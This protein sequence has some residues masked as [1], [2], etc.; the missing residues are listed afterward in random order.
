MHLTDLQARS[1]T[2]EELAHYCADHGSTTERA[3]AAKVD[4]LTA[5]LAEWKRV[6][7]QDEPVDLEQE[8]DYLRGQQETVFEFISIAETNSGTCDVET[9][10]D[11]MHCMAR[12]ESSCLEHGVDLFAP[13]HELSRLAKLDSL[14]S[15]L[16]LADL[17]ALRDRLENEGE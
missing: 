13:D 16:A 17:S 15:D 2:A 3:L 14:L 1:M 12:L 10:K 7:G 11:W 8:L 4:E 6:S 9:A 5:E